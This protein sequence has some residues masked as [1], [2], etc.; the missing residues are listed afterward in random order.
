[1]KGGPVRMVS[2]TEA[3]GLAGGFLV[4]FGYVPQLIRVW[5]LKD[6]SQISLSFNLM[7][8]GGTALW[9]AYGVTLG[10]LSVTLWN[11]INL[12]LLASLLLIKLRYGMKGPKLI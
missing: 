3:V 9:L 11:A 10:L 4:A 7:T 8:M 12:V 2:G 5:K 1:M 6:A